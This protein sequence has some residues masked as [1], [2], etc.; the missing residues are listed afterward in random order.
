[1]KT[2]LQS[3][4]E[5]LAGVNGMRE[6][7]QNANFYGGNLLRGQVGKWASGQGAH[8]DFVEKEVLGRCGSW[9]LPHCEGVW[10]PLNPL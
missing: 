4:H 9:V 2:L 8:I 3:P 10:A 1:M 7:T 5:N 6:M